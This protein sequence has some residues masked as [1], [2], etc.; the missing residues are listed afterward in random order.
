MHDH[1]L[2]PD[3]AGNSMVDRTDYHVLNSFHIMSDL[4]VT[5]HNSEMAD[6]S[7]PKGEIIEEL[8]YV[9]VTNEYGDRYAHFYHTTKKQN[10]ERLLARIETAGKINLQHWTR[11]YP[12]Y[13]SHAYSD[14]GAAEEIA[15][16]R[17][18]DERY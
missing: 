5:G 3:Q 4:T 10:I 16:E 17:T 8:Y 12:I 7:N 1:D 11:I 6:M 14:Y 13:G 2:E 9:A 15:W 18:H